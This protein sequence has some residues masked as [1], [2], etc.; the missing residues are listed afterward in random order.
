MILAACRYNGEGK[1]TKERRALEK[2]FKLQ[3][4]LPDAHHNQA[5]VHSSSKKYKQAIHGYLETM[6]LVD[7]KE[8]RS[9]SK[10][11]HV[12]GTVSSKCF[13]HTKT[14]QSKMYLNTQAGLDAQ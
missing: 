11:W 8:Q 2:A 12:L 7:A 5:I 1:H 10:G 14:I 4:D 9:P 3:P 13:C 6:R